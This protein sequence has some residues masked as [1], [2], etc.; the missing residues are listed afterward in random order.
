MLV[1]TSYK[2]NTGSKRKCFIEDLSQE[3]KK[4]YKYLNKQ[5]FRINNTKWLEK[6]V[7]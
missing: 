4:W 7:L 6:E 1:N 3:N 2:E 5:R